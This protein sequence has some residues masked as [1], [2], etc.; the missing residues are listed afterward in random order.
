MAYTWQDAVSGEYPA[1]GERPF[2]TT[3]RLPRARTWPTIQDA[4]RAAERSGVERFDV[5]P[6]ETAPA[7]SRDR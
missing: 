6:V 2:V 4:T 7:P 3:T 5:L 1:G